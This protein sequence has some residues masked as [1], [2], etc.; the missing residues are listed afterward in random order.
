MALCT[1]DLHIF[2]AVF[3]P[4]T[5][6]PHT[7]RGNSRT[8]L[9][10]SGPRD[11][12]ITNQRVDGL[13]TANPSLKLIRNSF[14]QITAKIFCPSR[15]LKCELTSVKNNKWKFHQ[16]AANSK[17]DYQ[18]ISFGASAQTEGLEWDLID[19]SFS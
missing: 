13:L 2:R 8:A 12:W 6:V 15:M 7:R 3:P 9:A 11:G 10:G 1:F 19:P 5:C 4:F 14:I 17:N 18:L 16:R